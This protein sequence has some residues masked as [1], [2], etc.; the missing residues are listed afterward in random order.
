MASKRKSPTYHRHRTQKENERR[1]RG[2]YSHMVYVRIH[3]IVSMCYMPT[4]TGSQ[5]RQ[6]LRIYEDI[7]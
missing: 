7:Y 4:Q 2:W 3:Q 5:L 1:R 6:P